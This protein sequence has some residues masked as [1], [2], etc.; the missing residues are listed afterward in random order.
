MGLFQSKNIIILEKI[1]EIDKELAEIKILNPL[2]KEFKEN[3]KKK[4]NKPNYEFG[5]VKKYEFYN[6]I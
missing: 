5:C 6:N 4:N 2:F 1:Y 3:L